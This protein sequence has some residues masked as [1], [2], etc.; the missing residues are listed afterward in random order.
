MGVRTAAAEGLLLEH[1]LDAPVESYLSGVAGRPVDRDGVVEL[2]NLA[3]A[4]PG[5]A[6]WMIVALNAYLRGA[7]FSWVALTA[8]PALRNAFR[9]LGLPLTE[10]APA[11]GEA[12]GAERA[13][14]GSYYQTRPVVVAGDVEEGF[15]RLE[16]TLYLEQAH[17]L[18]A[19][20]WEHAL[21]TGRGVAR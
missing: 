20:L 17:C 6:R 11:R 13:T 7:G 9:R 5:A 2:G 19:G 3:V 4:H 8:V 21:A 10:L 15:A 14:W 16:R 18:L 12:L 1:Y